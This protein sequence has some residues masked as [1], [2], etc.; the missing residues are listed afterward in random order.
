LRTIFSSSLYHI[1]KFNKNIQATR[2][3]EEKEKQERGGGAKDKC[4]FQTLENLIF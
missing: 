2:D 4:Y 1:L 3:E